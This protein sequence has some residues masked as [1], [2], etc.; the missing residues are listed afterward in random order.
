[1]TKGVAKNALRIL[2]LALLASLLFG[3]VVG[4]LIRRQLEKPVYYIGQA[5]PPAAEGWDSRGDARR[6]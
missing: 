6:G 4:T 1:M 3:L 5:G 2:I